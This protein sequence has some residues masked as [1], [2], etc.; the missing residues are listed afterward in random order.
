MFRLPLLIF[1]SL[2]VVVGSVRAADPNYEPPVSG[3]W[4]TVNLRIDYDGY[5]TMATQ[6]SELRANKRLSEEKFIEMA[7]QS[8]V[9][10]L[11]A[12]SRAMFALL[13]IEGAINLP[14]PDINENS[15]AQMLPD[16][17][18]IIL[19]YCNNN[20]AQAP[21]A[22]APKKAVAS[23]NISTYTALHSYGYKN[24]YELGPLLDVNTTKIP[25]VGERK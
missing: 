4:R 2:F 6:A 13:H 15:L 7:K 8:G 21:V 5:L 25:L 16:K 3:D 9:V 24:I 1:I 10:I 18:Q 14:F 22:M 20:F 19:I 12:R 11:D 23:L 17:N